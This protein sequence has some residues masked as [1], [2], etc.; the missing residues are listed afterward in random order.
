LKDRVEHLPITPASDESFKHIIDRFI[1]KKL[2]EGPQMKS[3]MQRIVNETKVLYENSMKK[4][5][6]KFYITIKI[7]IFKM[8]LF[9]VQHVLVAPNVKGLE[10]ETAGPPP[11]EPVGYGN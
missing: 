2:K 11:P 8:F 10:N 9:I 4:S 5:Q 3:V 6:C 1:D 7:K